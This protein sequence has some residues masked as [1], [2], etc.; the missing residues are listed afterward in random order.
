[1]LRSG[2]IVQT[3]IRLLLIRV[4]T[5]C[6]SNHIFLTRYPVVRRN[7]SSFRTI[8]AILGVSDFLGFLRYK[9]MVHFP[10][11]KL[12]EAT[13]LL[14]PTCDTFIETLDEC[15]KIIQSS[16]PFEGAHPHVTDAALPPSPL[17]V[18]SRKV[19]S[20]LKLFI[21]QKPFFNHENFKNEL[22]TQ[23]LILVACNSILTC[24]LCIRIS[25]YMYHS[26]WKIQ[27]V[28]CQWL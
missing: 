3:Q 23:T 11:Q 9:L 18:P 14:G 2:Q 20:L 24:K 25:S 13:S 22:L 12:T 15:M 6:S 28:V 27:S 17:K 19:N 1:M 7:Y 8:T 5:V 26:I 16:L 21:R 10:L 4:Y